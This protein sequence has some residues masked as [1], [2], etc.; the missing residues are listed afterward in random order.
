MKN[1]LARRLRVAWACTFSIWWWLAASGCGPRTTLGP[2]ASTADEAR[3]EAAPR[4][5]DPLA[6]YFSSTE[7]GWVLFPKALW[8]VSDGGLSWAQQASAGAGTSFRSMYWSGAQNG[9]LICDDGMLRTSNGGSTWARVLQLPKTHWLNA[10][11]VNGNNGYA[12]GGRLAGDFTAEPVLLQ[13]TSGGTDWKQATLNAEGL[14]TRSPLDLYSIYF[15]DGNVGWISGTSAIWRTDDGGVTWKPSRISVRGLHDAR[16]ERLQFSDGAHGFARYGPARGAVPHELVRSSDGG[17]SWNV[18][19]PPV[20]EETTGLADV[21]FLS[22]STGYSLFQG[23]LFKTM[24]G[25]GHWQ[26]LDPRVDA[27]LIYFVDQ[28]HGYLA[29]RDRSLART[30]DGGLTWQVCHKP[31]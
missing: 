26:S 16:L 18:V 31:E 14:G 9:W 8:Q 23:R 30:A 4:Q 2:S 17:Q 1:R 21:Q 11:W 28:D 13:T 24:D 5:G 19:D 15:L 22:E 25:G 29:G 20:E 6:L 10:V 12:V 7:S 27:D 3:K